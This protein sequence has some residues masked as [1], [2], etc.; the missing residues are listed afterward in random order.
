MLGIQRDPIESTEPL[1]VARKQHTVRSRHV[2]SDS[3]V[4]EGFGWVKVEDE[5]ETSSFENDDLVGFVFEGDVGLGGS[6]RWMKEK[7]RK[8]RKRERTRRRKERSARRE[9]K[10]EETQGEAIGYREGGRRRCSRT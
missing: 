3:E 5:E 7:G 10:C 2:D 4:D 6:R 9:R 8:R 1:L